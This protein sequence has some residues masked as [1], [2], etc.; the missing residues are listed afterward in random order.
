MIDALNR[1][2]KEVVELKLLNELKPITIKEDDLV[3][4][5]LPVNV[6]D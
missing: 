5:V 3:A 4:L 1:F 6:G 2:K